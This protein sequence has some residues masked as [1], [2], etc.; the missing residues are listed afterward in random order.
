MWG[1]AFGSYGS[2]SSS[3]E[4]LTELNIIKVGTYAERLSV[5]YDLLIKAP[6]D[7]KYHSTSVKSEILIP[8]S[9]DVKT[10]VVEIGE[11]DNLGD[12]YKG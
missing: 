11:G 10:R 8:V 7:K 5:V 3:Y 6:G 1:H 4:R 9:Q 12:L 2:L